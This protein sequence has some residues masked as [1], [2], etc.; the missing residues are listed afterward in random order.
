MTIGSHLSSR[1][2]KNINSLILEILRALGK[3]RDT[4]TLEANIQK[5]PVIDISH[6]SLLGGNSVVEYILGKGGIW[7][8]DLEFVNFFSSEFGGGA[9]DCIIAVVNKGFSHIQE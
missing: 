2:L 7:R 8:T 1:S 4:P 5:Q 6:C 9:Y 3:E